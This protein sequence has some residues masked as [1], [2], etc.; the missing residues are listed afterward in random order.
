MKTTLRERLIH[1]RNAVLGFLVCGGLA[2]CIYGIGY[3]AV[4]PFKL[5]AP[6]H[7]HIFMRGVLTLAVL[8]FGCVLAVHC[9][10]F[11]SHLGKGI[12]E[13]FRRRNPDD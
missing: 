1:I 8:L 7:A 5:P 10:L 2:A 3:Y 13:L 4:I 9:F 6:D 12:A 11:F